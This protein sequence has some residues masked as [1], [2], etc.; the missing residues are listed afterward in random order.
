MGLLVPPCLAHRLRWSLSSF[1]PGLILNLNLR[2]LC[3]LSSWDDRR[4]P[5]CPAVNY[6]LLKKQ[7]LLFIYLLGGSRVWNS[8][9]HTC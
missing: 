7:T 2:D 6:I 8:G 9:L 5:A 4:E 3:L 1:L